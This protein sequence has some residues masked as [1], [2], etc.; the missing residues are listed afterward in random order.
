[1]AKVIY[2]SG[3]DSSITINGKTYQT[4][5]SVN[6]SNEEEKKVTK[7]LQDAIKNIEAE[8]NDTITIS[9]QKKYSKSDILSVLGVDS[10]NSLTNQDIALYEIYKK[11]KVLFEKVK[12]DFEQ[13]KNF[14]KNKIE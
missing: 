7:R 4:R 9:Q 5:Q 11:N 13:R 12:Q 8:N 1:M 2:D 14:A 6:K 3:Y 10:M